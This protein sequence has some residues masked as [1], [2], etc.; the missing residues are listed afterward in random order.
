MLLLLLLRAA[1]LAGLFATVK[2]LALLAASPAS[3]AWARS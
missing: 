3:H 2:H 1:L